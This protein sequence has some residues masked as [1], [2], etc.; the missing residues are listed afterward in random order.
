MGTRKPSREEQNAR[1]LRSIEIAKREQEEGE[2]RQWRHATSAEKGKAIA[3]LM[4]YAE[5]FVRST[6]RPPLRGPMVAYK[7]QLANGRER[8]S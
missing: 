1:L 8:D 7:S 2:I 6:R 3:Q 5:A 4:D